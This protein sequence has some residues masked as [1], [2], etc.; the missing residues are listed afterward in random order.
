MKLISLSLLIAVSTSSLF[1]SQNEVV[2]VSLL[3]RK[4]PI[5]VYP[6]PKNSG[7]ITISSD[8]ESTLSFYLFDL[9]GQLIHQSILKEK[10]K[11]TIEGLTKGTYI[12]N[13]FQDDKNLEE[14]KVVLK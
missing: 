6:T 7:S 12:Y 5:K 13:A 11:Q 1:T 3:K 8:N 9:E 10:E 2:P 14:G 4:D